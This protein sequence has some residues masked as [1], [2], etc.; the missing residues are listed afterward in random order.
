M[1]L[2]GCED[3]GAAASAVRKEDDG[4]LELASPALRGVCSVL[5]ALKASEA[6]LT[7]AAV[8]GAMAVDP[9][10]DCLLG[11]RSSHRSTAVTAVHPLFLTGS[12][13]SCWSTLVKV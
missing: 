7:A 9:V 10:A 6:A 5:L 2:V 12:L 4:R 3:D 1:E 11:M 8:A 13:S